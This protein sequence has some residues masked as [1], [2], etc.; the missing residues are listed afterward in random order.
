MKKSFALSMF[1]ILF[2]L[3]P[4]ILLAQNSLT[5]AIIIENAEVMKYSIEYTLNGN[6]TI[7][8]FSLADQGGKEETRA[9]IAGHFNPKT[10]ELF[11]T[12]QRIISTTSS[13]PVSEFCLM[14]VTG[15]LESKGKKII[16]TGTFSATA[17]SSKVICGSGSIMLMDDRTIAQ[18]KDRSTKA[19]AKVRADSVKTEK[20]PVDWKFSETDLLSGGT[21]YF[22]LSEDIVKIEVVD[23]RFQDGDRITL[24]MNSETLAKNIEITNSVKGWTHHLLP[25]QRE[26]TYK[27][28]SESEGSVALTTVKVALRHGT[29]LDMVNVTLNKGDSVSI[30]LRK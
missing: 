13:T 12:E 1:F 9:V 5:G 22:S 17:K 11:F 14:T 8:G 28:I 30:V 27:L 18:V 6:N 16:F 20:K 3:S 26:L 23:D 29:S 7:S 24:I 15:K 25:D 21:K 2:I 10:K 4:L 19:I